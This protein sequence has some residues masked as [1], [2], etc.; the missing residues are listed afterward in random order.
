M[1]LLNIGVKLRYLMTIYYN[2]LKKIKKI[3]IR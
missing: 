1:L 2:N 3:R